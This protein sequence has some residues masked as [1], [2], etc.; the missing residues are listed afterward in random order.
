MKWIQT[1]LWLPLKVEAV[2]DTRSK[3]NPKIVCDKYLLQSPNDMYGRQTALLLP[4]VT[5]LLPNITKKL[6]IIMQ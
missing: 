6:R 1:K 4:I 3:A 2:K 5:S